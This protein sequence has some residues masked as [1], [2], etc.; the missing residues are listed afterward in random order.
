MQLDNHLAAG[1]ASESS[2]SEFDS[3]RFAHL[4]SLWIVPCWFA[5]NSRLGGRG[6]GKE[7]GEEKQIASHLYLGSYDCGALYRLWLV[8]VSP[9]SIA[10]LC[11]LLG[12]WTRERAGSQ[13]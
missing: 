13:L 7:S 8:P 11:A 4:G 2:E 5:L 1:G 6:A 9:S 12:K 10:A 3:G